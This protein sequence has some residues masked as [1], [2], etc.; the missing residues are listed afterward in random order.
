MAAGPESPRL[1]SHQQDV[2][3]RRRRGHR[4]RKGMVNKSA[5]V[6]WVERRPLHERRSEITPPRN[7]P[8]RISPRRRRGHGER[9]GMANK[10]AGVGWVERRP[11][12]G[13]RP[14][15]TPPR[16]P[17]TGCLTAEAQRARRKKRKG[18]Q[19]RGRRVGGE[20]APTWAPARNHPTA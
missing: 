20:A 4:G 11:L 7:P 16:N 12:N 5:G 14:G 6:G 13:R 10:S 2:S 1:A 9:K 19:E 8:T 15:I 3:P 18:Q 17:P